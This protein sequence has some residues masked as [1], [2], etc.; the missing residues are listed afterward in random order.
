MLNVGFRFFRRNDCGNVFEEV[1]SALLTG[2]ARAL[3]VF[4]G[5]AFVTKRGV[6][7]LAK[8]GHVSGFCAALWALHIEILPLRG[9]AGA[10]TTDPCSHFNNPSS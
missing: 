6:A 7:A 9:T 3:L 8:T 5:R 1:N 10:S 2:S 4:T